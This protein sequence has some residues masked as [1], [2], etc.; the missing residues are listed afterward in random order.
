MQHRLW[1]VVWLMFRLGAL[2]WGGPAAHIALM[3]QMV[4]TR[5]QW[6]SREQFLDLLGVTNLI[7]GPNSTEMAIHCS[8]RRAGWPGLLLGGMA[9]ILPAAGITLAWAWLYREYGVTPG[10]TPWWMGIRAVV[11]AILAQAVWRLGKGAAKGPR[12][13]LIGLGV[14]TA[15]L[16]GA[17][18][19]IA[20]LCGGVAGMLLLALPRRAGPPGGRAGAVLLAGLAGGGMGGLGMALH[21]SLAAA[22]GVVQTLS[23]TTLAWVF[24][25]IG[26]VL[27]GSGYVLVAYLQDELVTARGWLTGQQLLDAVAAGQITPGPVLSTATFVGFQLAG[28]V[29]ALVA[30]VA[31]F[32]P[33][34]VLVALVSPWVAVLRRSPWSARFLDAV[35]MS[36]VA[37]MAAAVVWLARGTWLDWRPVLLS[38]LALVLLWRGVSPLLLMLLGSVAGFLVSLAPW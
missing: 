22:A 2:S 4:V 27:F 14:L 33:A 17:P 9:F 38:A 26:M 23:L 6:L 13:V 1:E 15:A 30:T 8:Y 19:V 5:R 11:L 29:G 28:P 37:L 31:I 25:K 35:N 12:L 24:L 21:A 34:F 36:A 18:P 10:W 16:L 7:P 3:E 20:M 32:A